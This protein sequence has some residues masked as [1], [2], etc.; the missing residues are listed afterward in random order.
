[1]T[2]AQAGRWKGPALGCEEVNSHHRGSS[3]GIVVI[4]IRLQDLRGRTST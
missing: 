2:V 4:L 1:M 3:M